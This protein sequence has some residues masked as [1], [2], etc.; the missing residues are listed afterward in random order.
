MSDATLDRGSIDYMWSHA[1]ISD[2]THTGLQEH[3]LP[4]NYDKT[5]CDH[6]Q[7][8]AYREEQG[9]N[10]IDPYNIYGPVCFD[11]S[12]NRSSVQFNK[13][14]FGYD[15][16][17]QGYV[18]KYL[19]LHHV[20]QALHANTTNL[21]YPWNLCSEGERKP[22]VSGKPVRLF[23]DLFKTVEEK[24]S[25][26]S[27]SKGKP[28]ITFTTEELRKIGDSFPY[29]IKARFARDLQ[30][31]DIGK[32]LERG[33]FSGFRVIS[34]SRFIVVITLRS[35][36]DFLRLLSRRTW[37]ANGH[38]M[39]LSK[40]DPL[41][42]DKRD[43]PMVLVWVT[44]KH[45][46]FFLTSAQSLFSVVKTL[47]KPI[48]MDE[49][50]T[51]GGYFNT[52]RVL[53]EMDASKARQSSILYVLQPGSVKLKSFMIF[54]LFAWLV[55]D[56]VTAAKLIP[57][58]S[59]KSSPAGEQ[60]GGSKMLRKSGQITHTNGSVF[61][62]KLQD[63][64]LK[65]AMTNA[66][67]HP[68]N[69]LW[70]FWK[71]P[72]LTLIQTI[73]G[74]QIIHCQF[75][76]AAL[77][78]PLWISSVY[79]R[80]TRAERA[81]LWN[82]ISSWN[83]GMDPWILG[84]DFNCIHSLD[85]HKGNCNPCY[86]SVEDFR[87]CMEASNLLYIHP[88]GGHF[89]WSGERS[90]GK[91]WRR[92]DHIFGNQHL[93]DMANR[94]H[95]S[96]LSKGASD[97]RPFL[98]EL[99]M[100]TYSGPKP[101]RFL[102]LWVSHHTLE[103][104]IKSFWENNKTYNGMKGLGRKLKNLKAILTKWSRDDFGNIFH[105]L[106]EAES[107]ASRAQDHFEANQ[108]PES[109]VEFNKSNAE[110]LLLSKRETDFWRQKSCIRWL[111][112]GDASTKFFHNVVKNRRQK[113]RISSLKDD[114]GRTIEEASNIALHAIDYY[115][116]IYSDEPVSIDPQLLSY[117]PNIINGEDNLMLCA[118]PQEEEIRGAI[119]D[120]NSHS[121]PGPDGY[122]GTFFKTYWHIIHDEVTRATQEFFLGL[123][124]PKSY[125]ATLLTLIPKVDN[126]KS[127][128][129]Y[130]PISLSTFLSKVNTKILANRLGSI[131][132][133]L[134]SPEQS[135]FQAGKG[136]EENILLT[137]EM[138]H[139][140]DNTSGSANIAIKVDFAKAFDRIS[141]QFLEVTLSSFGFSPHGEIKEWKDSPSTMFPIY[142]RLM[143]SALHILLYSGDAD[144]VV[145]VTSTRYALD[146]MNLT[147][148]KPWHPWQ[149]PTHK[150]VAGYKVEYK[151]ITFATVKGGGHLV[152]QTNPLSAFTLLNM[153]IT[154]GGDHH[155]H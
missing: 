24:G 15:P 86:N 58:P 9:D 143:A 44:L 90:Q 116:N 136:V 118:V 10:M 5:A 126:P 35:Q 99:S 21:P 64:K 88:S 46:P 129:D 29:A 130:R 127:L 8:A 114:H 38:H 32:S 104:T 20:Q 83:V 72:S 6:F 141:W 122:N 133:K 61:R 3:C 53:V 14:R 40:W 128:G 137:Q 76:S 25:I 70:I 101:F 149:H 81:N 55:V 26:S 151:G 17:E 80:H 107:R 108:N 131:L 153:F 73:E 51:R 95:L 69:Q 56:G 87:E 66:S 111:K 30:I 120:L 105:Q 39:Y 123:P 59:E 23:S 152:P 34:I 4:K 28:T 65:L 89:S 109:L 2:A 60:R 140:L 142:K 96:M 97:H 119:W 54:L 93:M 82:A 145:P 115:T 154:R 47:G 139:C 146:A 138:I 68:N 33:G 11:Y 132:H 147:I 31:A 67:S 75:N 49:T 77:H 45:I 52:A 100:D 74:S 78:S 62:E 125:G 155:H 42:E 36:T 102:D 150:E 12:H 19:N 106:K 148:L 43:S 27:I 41:L 50:T 13:R 124:I 92:L 79:G 121:A 112:E 18:H 1:L 110:L 91:L 71:E 103:S 16:C 135:G 63:Y 7:S 117:I 85:Q 84:G 22:P 113:L 37:R 48:Q 57:S 94:V 144:S 134:I 98:L